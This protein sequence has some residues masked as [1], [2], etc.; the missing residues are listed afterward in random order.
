MGGVLRGLFH[1]K[2]HVDAGCGIGDLVEEMLMAGVDSIGIEGSTD[3]EKYFDKTRIGGYFVP[4]K[5]RVL[6]LDLRQPIKLP[7][8]DL[9]TCFEV[10]EHIDPWGTDVFLDNLSQFSDQIVM[11][12]CTTQGGGRNH[13]N[14]QPR[15]WWDGK[16]QERGYCSDL[17]SIDRIREGVKEH[18]HR[19]EMRWW[20]DRLVVYKR[21]NG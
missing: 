13:I 8:C 18:K 21:V 16:M 9:C 19:E 1:P 6:M 3:I 5:K 15:E 11:S 2:T 17:D 14:I 10:A 20:H 7:K 12:I 4:V